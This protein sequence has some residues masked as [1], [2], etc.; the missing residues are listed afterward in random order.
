MTRKF[1]AASA[2]PDGAALPHP[3]VFLRALL[4][5]L[6]CQ[7]ACTVPLTPGYKILKESRD[8]QFVSGA[9]PELHVRTNFTLQNIGNSQLQFIDVKFPAEKQFGRKNL[10]VAVDGH[11]APVSELPR[12]LQADSPN[13]LRI[14]FNPAWTQKQKRELVIEYALSSPEDSGSRITIGESHFHVGSRGGFPVLQ[15]PRH[16]L[17]PYPKRPD[18]TQVSI[19][20]PE[21]FLVLSRGTPA[22][23]KQIGGEAVYRFVMRQDDLESF[24]VGGRYS[25]STANHKAAAVSFWTLQQLREDP[26]QAE[27]RLTAA[28]NTLQTAFGSFDKNIRVTHV[29]ESPGLRAHLPGEE[30]AAAVP[31]PGGVLVN[32]A[33]LALGVNSDAFLEKVTHALAHNWFGDE[34]YP[35]ADAA[36]GLGEGLADYATIVVDEAGG[37]EGGRR[38]DIDKFLREYDAAR[39][40]AA[41]KPLGVTTLSSAP[42]ER[43]IAL[44]KAP[45][46][47]IALED[48]FGEAT[49]RA[50]INHLVTLLRGQDV[51]Y[52][53]LRSALEESTGKNLAEPFRMWLYDK[54][55]PEEFRARYEAA[56]ASRP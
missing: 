25:E 28:W 34:M 24:V 32:P 8:I 49:V 54:G 31:F 10:R 35:T 5:F 3:C 48:K 45:L 12:E 20:V 1:C 51:G 30:G 52:D 41:E 43:R 36:L 15:H 4:I 2:A 46:F 53:D 29:V 9:A 38:R 50:G 7:A 42:A 39:K 11:D 26:A 47:F 37:G 22:G 13:T 56:D 23:R 21:G 27:S 19:R 18:K 33:A 16:V 44:A 40:Q 17:S 55:I 14:S 6:V